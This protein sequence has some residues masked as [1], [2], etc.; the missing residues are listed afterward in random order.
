M[1]IVYYVLGPDPAVVKP[2]TVKDPDLSSMLDPEFLKTL[3]PEERQLIETLSPEELKQL[4]MGV[5]PTSAAS[6]PPQPLSP[7]HNAL[8]HT[9]FGANMPSESVASNKIP[10][11]MSY[12]QG[13]PDNIGSGGAQ[14]NPM[15]DALSEDEKRLLFGGSSVPSVAAVTPVSMPPRRTS[16]NRSTN[17]RRDTATLPT[18]AIT[19]VSM[20]GPASVPGSGTSRPGPSQSMT[21]V[22]QIDPGTNSA[23]GQNAAP[24]QQN[25]D[26]NVT[27]FQNPAISANIHQSAAV[28]YPYS[29]ANPVPPQ[30]YIPAPNPNNANQ[31]SVAYGPTLQNQRSHSVP[32][33]VVAPNIASSQ[34]VSHTSTIPQN[35]SNQQAAPVS[36]NFM[37][38][39]T[40][41]QHQYY[42]ANTHG[43]NMQ[44]GA[45]IPH[46]VSNPY[47][48]LPQVPFQ[49]PH[50]VTTNQYTLPGTQIQ[51]GSPYSSI[52]SAASYQPGSMTQSQGNSSSS[53]VTDN[54]EQLA[55]IEYMKQ[56]Q[57]ALLQQLEMQNKRQVELERQLND[58]KLQHEQNVKRIE[59]ENQEKMMKEQQK[60][61]Q[62]QIEKQ[63]KAL[64]KQLEEQKAQQQLFMNQIMMNYSYMQQ[65]YQQNQ[66]VKPEAVNLNTAGFND[67]YYQTLNQNQQVSQY[68]NA[69]FQN[70][71]TNF[72]PGNTSLPV[73]SAANS[74]NSV[75]QNSSVNA[76]Q[77]QVP[78]LSN[79]HNQSSLNT[80]NPIPQNEAS[81][82]PSY[83]SVQ[84]PVSQWTGYQQGSVP[85]SHNPTLAAPANIGPDINMS[86]YFATYDPKKPVDHKV[87]AA[88]MKQQQEMMRQKQ[89]QEQKRL[90]E[91]AAQKVPA[92]QNS[93]VGQNQSSNQSEQQLQSQQASH[94]SYQNFGQSQTRTSGIGTNVA[95]TFTN[96]S[97]LEQQS[98]YQST[99]IAQTQVQKSTSQ[100]Q[101]FEQNKG[102]HYSE[103]GHLNFQVQS[104]QAEPL[105]P[106]NGSNISAQTS[107]Q[108]LPKTD[109]T[110]A[111]NSDSF[112]N[113]SEIDRQLEQ[114]NAEVSRGQNSLEY[115][116]SVTKQSSLPDSGLSNSS[117]LREVVTENAGQNNVD[118][119]SVM[120]VTN[121]K[122]DVQRNVAETSNFQNCDQSSGDQTLLIKFLP[123]SNV[124]R[125][126][127][128]ARTSELYKDAESMSKLKS[129]LD[130]LEKHVVNMHKQTLNGPTILQR[131]WSDLESRFLQTVQS[132]CQLS[133]SND[134]MRIPKES[135]RTS[136]CYTHNTLLR[137]G[138]EDSKMVSVDID[139]I[140]ELLPR[141]ALFGAVETEPHMK[142]FWN[143]VEEFGVTL[144]VSFQ[145]R[146]E[147]RL[148]FQFENRG[149]F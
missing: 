79:Y 101:T 23:F 142:T 143:S 104:L 30:Q 55:Q 8:T 17:R 133:I 12:N 61:I 123:R 38:H 112:D 69:T 56:Q 116:T 95:Q 10:A 120:S 62:V 115:G 122:Q 32:T 51:A 41:Y 67:V 85:V 15:L 1:R 37:Y 70:Q 73:A 5:A 31:G 54:R 22:S 64:E 138:N 57:T 87:L 20:H 135:N 63:Q 78:N 49:P 139:S 13:L 137:S 90:S 145:S 89:V 34:G 98:S 88:M 82:Y 46:Q 119:S 83:Q 136:K 68:Q 130:K 84:G 80:N 24:Y 50:A 72:L 53:N 113:M 19:P 76:T 65:Q 129:D 7:T 125:V 21:P 141:F 39:Q 36:S 77:N 14:G 144:V 26:P 29:V 44:A 27:P 97:G 111:N 3:T 43:Q 45:T 92:N 58:Q 4:Q 59:T 99:S 33:A 146:N 71:T 93:P 2:N 148:F 75:P 114:M 109:S 96:P 132:S 124:Q 126:Q 107:N 102:S 100:S 60:L 140:S 11:S 86:E 66:R 105:K 18:T 94:V 48:S 118:S 117:S 40:G 147:V 42:Q 6:A 81:N 106:T 149:Y 91:L 121:V 25:P 131:E 28:V 134:E 74:T 103:S 47:S 52:N 9:N 110:T 128:I 127:P 16:V 108:T 35:V